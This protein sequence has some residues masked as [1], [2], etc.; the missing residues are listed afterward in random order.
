MERLVFHASESSLR[1]RVELEEAAQQDQDFP[2]ASQTKIEMSSGQ[3]ALHSTHTHTN[4]AEASPHGSGSRRPGA[5]VRFCYTS[6][7]TRV[8]RVAGSLGSR[9]G[10]K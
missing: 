2:L 7:L 10:K 4:D 3:S 9:G 1:E 8:G 5:A 6:S